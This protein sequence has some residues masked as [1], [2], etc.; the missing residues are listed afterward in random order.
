M[1]IAT[2]VGC[3]GEP[4]KFDELEYMG[5]GGYAFITCSFPYRSISA[6]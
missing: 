5:A 3:N 4:S 2:T 1:I 6:I